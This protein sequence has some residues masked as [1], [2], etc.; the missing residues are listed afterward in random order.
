M[1]SSPHKPLITDQIGRYI[2]II[3]H[4]RRHF[5]TLVY[6]LGVRFSRAYLI[7][8]THDLVID[9]NNGCNEGPAICRYPKGMCNTLMFAKIACTFRHITTRL[10]LVVVTRD[11]TD[12]RF[13]QTQ[14]EWKKYQIFNSTHISNSIAVFRSARC[15]TSRFVYLQFMSLR[16]TIL[17]QQDTN[18]CLELPH[19]ICRSYDPLFIQQRW[20]YL[21]I[22]FREGAFS[23][24]FHYWTLQG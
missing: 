17:R 19:V 10:I 23:L 12:C 14:T 6:I 22:L 7:W 24:P 18:P 9:I 8:L 21:T 4:G 1:H 20:E 5:F 16:W 3:P 11:W 15:V 2:M 13:A